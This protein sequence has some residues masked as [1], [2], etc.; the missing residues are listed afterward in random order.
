MSTEP[1]SGVVVEGYRLLVVDE[2]GRSSGIRAVGSAVLATVSALFG[3]T[4]DLEGRSYC[5]RVS[6]D[7][8]GA[9]VAERR[10]RRRRTAEAARESAIARHAA[11]QS[12]DQQPDWQ[13][14]LNV[15]S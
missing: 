14:L 9:V 6:V 8:T 2:P 4:E 15:S 5:L 10:F 12:E 3:G 11:C 1:N 13:T 7:A